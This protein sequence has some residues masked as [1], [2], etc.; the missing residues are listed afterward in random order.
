MTGGM[1]LLS[2]VFCSD[3]VDVTQE[4]EE[5]TGTGTKKQKYKNKIWTKRYV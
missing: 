5:K 2:A 3:S 4:S 1:N